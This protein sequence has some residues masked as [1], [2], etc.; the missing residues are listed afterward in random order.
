MDFVAHDRRGREKLLNMETLNLLPAFYTL[1]LPEHMLQV[2]NQVRDS[3]F[4]LRL[5]LFLW[6]GVDHAPGTSDSKVCYINVMTSTLINPVRGEAQCSGMSMGLGP[7]T[8]NLS[9]N[10]MYLL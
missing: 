1:G 4:S 6:S 10:S 7:P 9:E 2:C 8:C 3:S 5:L